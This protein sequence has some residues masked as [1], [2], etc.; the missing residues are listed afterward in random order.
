MHDVAKAAGVSAQTVSRALNGR[1]YVSAE[2]RKRV[3]DAAAQVGYSPNVIGQ[4]LRSARSPMVGLVVSDIGN[5]FYA[6]LHR[7]IETPLRTAGLSVLLL[8]C[9]DDPEL[10]S[11]Q[12]DLL[13][14]Y[15]PAGLVL[16]PAT[17]SRFSAR[18]VA[19]FENVVLV[20]RTLPDVDVPTIV[21]N[22]TEA[23]AAAADEL[24]AAGHRRVAAVLGPEGASTT[25]LRE[26]GL[27]RATAARPTRD[28]VVRYSE[29][30]S[31]AA[32]TA[33]ADLLASDPGIT[34]VL[35]FNVPV[36]EGILIAV[37]DAGL[38]VPQDISVIGFT[39][40]GWMAAVHPAV[41]AV[42]QPV[43]EMGRLAGDLIVRMSVGEQF[44]HVPHLVV[45]G[46]LVRRES[47]APPRE[48]RR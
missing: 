7:A 5:P 31:L 32:R 45:P 29:G 8:N 11:A 22:E 41:T 14:S 39:D 19:L 30:T 23:F 2:A 20:S 3:L 26:A 18:Q 1:G 10:E 12:L 13:A 33:T 15:R 43:E 16:S 35:G 4:S 47:V 24:F 27:Q 25:H 6:R 38:R 9:D 28:S 21:T 36:T 48:E 44:D 17:G 37:R 42:A 34:A 40:A 46:E